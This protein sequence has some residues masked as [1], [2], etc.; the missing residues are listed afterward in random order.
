MKRATGSKVEQEK[1]SSIQ[2]FSELV[3]RALLGSKLG[4]QYG[5][6]RDLYEALGY[7]INI[8][9]ADYI[10]R[11]IRQDIASAIINRPVNVTWRGGVEIMES[12]DDKETALEKAWKELDKELGLKSRFVRLDKLA[13]IGSYGALV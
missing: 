9:Y 8:T 5:T 3:N 10:A 1:S 4:M 13:G 12:S 11:Y 6:D 7:P 2:V